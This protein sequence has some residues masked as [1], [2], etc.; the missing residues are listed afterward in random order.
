[1]DL[2]TM[3]ITRFV[4]NQGIPTRDAENTQTNTLK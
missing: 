4:F 1:M 3:Q 2:M